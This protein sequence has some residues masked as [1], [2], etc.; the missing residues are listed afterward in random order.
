MIE[1]VDA[2]QNRDCIVRHPVK[3]EKPKT[4]KIENQINDFSKYEST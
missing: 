3:I 1:T 4:K 2:T